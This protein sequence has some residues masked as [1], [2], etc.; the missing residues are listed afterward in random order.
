METAF[1]H[2]FSQVRVHTD[3][4]AAQLSSALNARPFTIGSDVVFATG[5]YE[6]GTMI[7]DVLIAHE[8]AHVV[9]QRDASASSTVRQVA[10]ADHDSLEAEADRSAMGVI[11]SL[12]QGATG[13]LR[14]TA[15]QAL[16]RLRAG[17]RLQRCGATPS[18][19][20]P[21][22][23]PAVPATGAAPASVAPT[24]GGVTPDT[25]T[26]ISKVTKGGGTLGYT[27][28]DDASQLI[29][30][31]K[32]EVDATT[33]SCTFKPV[34]VSL[35]L[36]S[37]YPMVTPASPTSAT[38]KLPQ[39]GDKEV[40]VFF[41]ITP[42]ISDLVRQGEQ[43]HVDDLNLAFKQTLEPCSAE[44]NKLAGQKFAAKTET[45]CFIALVAKLGFDPLNCTA[46][47]VA[48]TK[49]DETRDVP[50]GFHDFD[51]VL[52]SSSCDKIVAGNKRADTNEIG[53]PSVAPSKFIPA[54]TKCPQKAA[55]APPPSMVG[56]PASPPG[57][58][59]TPPKKTPEEK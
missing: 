1:G 19:V 41:Q 20:K 24:A 16:P 48:L 14:N 28:I 55:A 33:G 17:L 22:P 54:S 7:G 29:C 36:T 39:C 44:L 46:E 34:A 12:W 6:P 32:L 37:K 50:L 30:A 5:Q 45:E 57:G 27:K 13:P 4:R 40:P 26:N 18:A 49:K 11:A 42:E 9:Q 15:S 31:P 56:S 58:G 35:S 53:D 43:E 59:S 47:F 8:L 51:P 21:T 23:L 2:S 25:I 52:I 38:L 10:E 3:S